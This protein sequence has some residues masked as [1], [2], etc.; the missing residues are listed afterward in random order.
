M[1]H[2]WPLDAPHRCSVCPHGAE[3]QTLQHIPGPC[4]GIVCR[5]R[6]RH[7][8]TGTFT[9]HPL[10]SC[11]ALALSARTEPG[12]GS[13]FRPV[14]VAVDGREK[15]SAQQPHFPLSRHVVV[16]KGYD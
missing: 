1:Q 16:A 11:R 7:P 12:G 10:H 6:R 5:A 9:S 2:V 15:S 13:A 3:A 14:A 4:C 8:A